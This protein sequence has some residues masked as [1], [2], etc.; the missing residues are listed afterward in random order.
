MEIG[1]RAY[2]H[3]PSNRPVLHAGRRVGDSKVRTVWQTTLSLA[4]HGNGVRAYIHNLSNRQEL[5]A[6]RRVGPGTLRFVH[7]ITSPSLGLHRIG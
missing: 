5:F 1:V 6:G 3:N 7:F 2:I 4:V